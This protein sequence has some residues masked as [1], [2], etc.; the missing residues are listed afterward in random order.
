MRKVIAD[1][2]LLTTERDLSPYSERFLS[3][4][5]YISAGLSK[6]LL[7]FFEMCKGIEQL[8]IN[9]ESSRDY[10]R[11]LGQ[12]AAG[13]PIEVS[14]RDMFAANERVDEARG[15]LL[16]RIETVNALGDKLDSDVAEEIKLI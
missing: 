14:E 5:L 7:S 8:H 15:T 3:A 2:G 6:R 16:R 9:L 4:R 1:K 11:L 12:M 10:V 13:D